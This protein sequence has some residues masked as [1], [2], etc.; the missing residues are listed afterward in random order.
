MTKLIPL[1][2]YSCVSS[3]IQNIGTT[4]PEIVSVTW[5]CF[6]KYKFGHKLEPCKWRLASYWRGWIMIITWFTES[7]S[8][9]I[10]PLAMFWNLAT[11]WCHEFQIWPPGGATCIG[12]KFGHQVA[13]Q[14]ISFK[15]GHQMTQVADLSTRWHHITCFANLATSWCHLH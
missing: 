1:C 13:P 9:S 12:C 14:Y 8:G 6:S 10:V 11:R 15:F 4:D 2:I 5:S 7:I 3:F